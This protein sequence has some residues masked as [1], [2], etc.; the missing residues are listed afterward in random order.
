[1]VW[2]YGPFSTTVEFVFHSSYEETTVELLSIKPTGNDPTEHK[3][4]FFRGH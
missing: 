2:L 3:P 1:M 4:F